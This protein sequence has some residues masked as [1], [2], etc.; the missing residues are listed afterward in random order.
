MGWPEKVSENEDIE[1]E[2]KWAILVKTETQA[3]QNWGRGGGR[4]REGDSFLILTH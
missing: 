3:S 2:R 1:P 4:R